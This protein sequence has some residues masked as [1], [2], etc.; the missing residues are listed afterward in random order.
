MIKSITAINY[1]GESIKMEL[2]Y[3]ENSGFAVLEV[4]G[5]G[6]SKANINLTDLSS[7]NGSLFNSARIEKRNIVLTLKLLSMPTVELIRQ[8]T[9]KYFP[10]SKPIELV[11]ETDIRTCKAYGY[12]ESNEPI[13]FSAS[14][15]TQISI[16]CPDPNFY[17]IG[18]TVTV[19]AGIEPMFEFPFSNE[20]LTV[21]LLEMGRIVTNQEQT[22][23]YEGDSEIGIVIY[24]HALGP[25]TNLTI[26]NSA[27]REVMKLDTTRL[28]ALTGSGLIAGDDIIISTVKGKKTVQLLRNGVYTNIINCL[29]KNADWFQLTKGDNLFAFTADTGSL[30]LQFRIENQIVY[31]GV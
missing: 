2:V 17:S 20:S 29:D 12:V 15:T 19:F 22:I 25:A 1:L 27:T 8:K 21:N 14:Q 28:L 3:P 26:Y 5:L 23:Y 30:N 6:P 11:I 9:Y 13:I 16:I 18:S 10:L 24:I 4:T 7:S 31:E